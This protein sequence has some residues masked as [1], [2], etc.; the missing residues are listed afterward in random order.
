MANEPVTQ[1]DALLFG[2][3]PRPPRALSEPMATAAVV[4]LAVFL[5]GTGA[6]SLLITAVNGS[7]SALEWI[8]DA[9]ISAAVA[10]MTYLWLHLK[11]SRT[12]LLDVERKGIVL[13][14]QLRLAATIQRNLLPDIPR[15][16]PGFAWAA[17]MVPAGVVGG[18][19]YDFLEPAPGIA[20]MIIGDISG[21]GI[22]AALLHSSL[23]A[24]FRL[25]AAETTDP[26][27]I[28]ARLG[29][30]LH[31]QTGGVPYA[32]AIVA[33]LDSASMTLTVVNAG[34]PAG[35]LLRGDTDRPLD[36]G[37]PPLGLLP[38][39][40]YEAANL[41]LRPGDLGVFVTDGVTEAL[42]GKP[43]SLRD[44]LRA[45]KRFIHGSGSV[46]E[47]C[48]LLLRAAAEAPGP[49]GAGDW[50]DDATALVFRAV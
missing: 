44:L 9:L 19:F 6:E 49:V 24:V 48:D 25:I 33:R 28:A 16:S 2:E 1:A 11:A 32:T 21:K 27:E 43:M 22:P 4:G 13:A 35:L 26:V 3:A 42:E 47:A 15:T 14:E 46:D 12:R 10:G 37:G 29:A 18:D 40:A 23:R 39:A 36:T 34:H 8:S 30:A 7:R 5:L 17:R 45:S 38:E 20:L 50:H 31:G 41:D